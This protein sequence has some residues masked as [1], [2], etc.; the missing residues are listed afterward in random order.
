MD[1][2]TGWGINVAESAGPSFS[3]DDAVSEL[4][5][6]LAPTLVRLARAML[7]DEALA[8]DAVQEAFLLLA[9][10][11]RDIP[12]DQRRGWL[13]RTV[14]NHALNLRRREQRQD[15]FQQQLK[16]RGEG[17][18]IVSAD[19]CHVQKAEDLV[20]LRTALDQL[21]E[22]QQLV[23]RLRLA[24]QKSFQE[25][26]EQLALPL[27]TVLSRMRLAVEKLRSKLT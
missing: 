17:Y 3:D 5:R 26:A 4:H 7:R 11:C 15:R 23:V 6:E 9:L 14:Q 24:E 10:K 8:E 18:T 22:A 1:Q 12:V 21:P 13:V 16:E 20:R 27:G 25:I 2:R 19:E